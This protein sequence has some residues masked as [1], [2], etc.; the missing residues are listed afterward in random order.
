MGVVNQIQ[1]TVVA[2]IHLFYN[3]LYILKCIMSVGIHV[4]K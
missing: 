3:K 4:N 1:S 2:V